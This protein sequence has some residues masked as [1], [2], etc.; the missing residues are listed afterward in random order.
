M[1]KRM[2][3]SNVYTSSKMDGNH[4]EMFQHI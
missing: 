2:T 4:S 1:Q 3:L